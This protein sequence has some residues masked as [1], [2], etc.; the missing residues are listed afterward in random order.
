MAEQPYD[1][2][3]VGAGQTGCALA[4]KIAEKGVI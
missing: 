4:G 1:L 2:A 3:I